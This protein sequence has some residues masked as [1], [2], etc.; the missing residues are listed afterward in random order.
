MVAGQLHTTEIELCSIPGELAGP[1]ARPRT[2]SGSTPSSVCRAVIHCRHRLSRGSRRRW[3]VLSPP[4]S[5]QI[6]GRNTRNAPDMAVGKATGL[7]RPESFDFSRIAPSVTGKKTKPTQPTQH[8]TK[9]TKKT[10][11]KTNSQD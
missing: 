6:F 11:T 7:M 2:K 3:K 5:G 10:K 8:T 4:Q 9:D 1:C